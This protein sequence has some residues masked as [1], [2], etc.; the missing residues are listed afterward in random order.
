MA[1]RDE[2]AAQPN[3]KQKLSIESP[4]TRSA[5]E[6]EADVDPVAFLQREQPDL[7]FL[8][9]KV[10]GDGQFLTRCTVKVDHKTY[11]KTSDKGEEGAK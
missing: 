1:D 8:F 11:Y 4:K 10:E 6:M 3:K 7:K 2:G 9:K 5:L